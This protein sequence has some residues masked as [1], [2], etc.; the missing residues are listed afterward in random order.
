MECKRGAVQS[1]SF[2]VYN[3]PAIVS[4]SFKEMTN[5]SDASGQ[6]I[7]FKLSSACLVP[8]MV[9]GTRVSGTHVSDMVLKI[10]KSAF[11][12]GTMDTKQTKKTPAD[13]SRAMRTFG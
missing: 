3:I 7:P 5:N 8:G 10:M 9:A 2:Y 1:I 11:H 4:L 13:I 12:W 6:T